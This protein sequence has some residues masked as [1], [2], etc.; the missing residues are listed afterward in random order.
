ML[1]DST[2]IFLSCFIEVNQQK[3]IFPLSFDEILAA[4]RSNR[5]EELF[6]RAGA[7]DEDESNIDTETLV[8]LRSTIGPKTSKTSS[9]RD[10]RNEISF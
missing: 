7:P 3:K 4:H 9:Y 10:R 5:L 2:D 1:F 8:P 6:G